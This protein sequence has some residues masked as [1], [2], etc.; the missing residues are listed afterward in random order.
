MPW[1][2]EIKGQISDPETGKIRETTYKYKTNSKGEITDLI[3][4]LDSDRSGGKHGHV[5]DV[6][7]GDDY[8]KRTDGRDTS[9]SSSSG[10][11]IAT[12]TLTCGGNDAQLNTLRQWRDEV[13][14]A[15]EIGRQLEKYYDKTGPVVARKV[16]D[17]PTLAKT[18][19]YPFVKPAVWLAQRRQAHSKIRHLYDVAIYLVFLTGLVYGSLVYWVCEK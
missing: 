14:Q 9:S 10:C 7:G 8:S 3:Y 17:N 1:S 4:D 11:Y 2:K 12:A 15:T 16:A 13:M 6:H 19:L 18:F 5:W